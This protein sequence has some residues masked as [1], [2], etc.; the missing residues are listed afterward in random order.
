M[1]KPPKAATRRSAAASPMRSAISTRRA[2]QPRRDDGDRSAIALRAA[3]LVA[4]LGDEPPDPAAKLVDDLVGP[5]LLEEL[6]RRDIEALAHEPGVEPRQAAMAKGAELLQSSPLRLDQTG[7]ERAVERR[8][9]GR[10]EGR[11]HIA[12][13]LAPLLQAL[14]GEVELLRRRP[15]HRLDA[16]VPLDEGADRALARIVD[17]AELPQR[18]P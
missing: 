3:A 10:G 13:A 18:Q 17:D 4:A 1:R 11:G 15:L 6:R 5:F 12:D 14:D 2:G 7:L 9:N 16:R 8:W